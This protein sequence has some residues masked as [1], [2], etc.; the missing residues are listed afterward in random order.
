[1][2][3]SK[4]NAYSAIKVYLLATR[5]LHIAKGLPDPGRGNMARLSQVLRQSSQLGQSK[6]VRL[7]IMPDILVRIKEAW[8]KERLDHD[9][10]KLM[11]WAAWFVSSAFFGRAKYVHSH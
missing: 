9:G 5:Q 4:G 8:E 2:L 3:A 1:V 10:E 11:L 6:F 7:P